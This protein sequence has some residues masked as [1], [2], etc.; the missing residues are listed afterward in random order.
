MSFHFQVYYC[1]GVLLHPLKICHFE[2]C[3]NNLNKFLN[4]ANRNSIYCSLLC[5][6]VENE[7]TTIKNKTFLGFILP[8]QRK[9]ISSENCSN[10]FVPSALLFKANNRLLDYSMQSW[11]CY[12]RKNELGCKVGVCK[13]CKAFWRSF[14]GLAPKETILMSDHNKTIKKNVKNV[15]ELQRKNASLL[16][17]NA[18]YQ[19]ENKQTMNKLRKRISYWKVRCKDLKSA[20]AQWRKVERERKGFF[21]VDEVESDRW[22]KFYTF[23]DELIEKEHTGDPEK[24]SLHKELIRSE[25]SQLGKFNKSGNK[26]GIRT[27]KLSSRILNYVLGLAHNLGK[28]KYEKEATLR[29]LPCWSTLTK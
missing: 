23:I 15:E 5:D 8:S 24:I 7:T 2:E 9:R 25:T 19:N 22:F 13:T 6:F 20:V 27:T 17:D 29:S 1:S 14:R 26:R 18:E 21:D 12:V 3:Q 11:E 28:V 10:L 16:I 4:D